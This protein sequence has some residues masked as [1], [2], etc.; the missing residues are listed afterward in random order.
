MEKAEAERLAQAIN[1]LRPDW[2]ARSVLTF[3]GSKLADRAYRDAALA[4]TAVAVDP[5]TATPARVLEDGP[6]WQTARPTGRTTPAVRE[7]ECPDH[8]GHRSWSCPQ[9]AAEAVPMPDAARTLI[10]EVR[11][12][13]RPVIPARGCPLADETTPTH[14]R[15]AEAVPMPA[16]RHTAPQDAHAAEDGSPASVGA[17]H[18][19]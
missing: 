13:P 8:P 2:P 17:A 5:T 16:E 10:D 6:W 14:T 12:R 3:I 18:R 7:H 11:K 4:L 9:C 19:D 15:A 1:A